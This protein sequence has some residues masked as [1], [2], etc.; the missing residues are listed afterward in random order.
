MTTGLIIDSFS[1][2]GGA[3]TGIRLAMGRDPDIAINHDGAALAMHAANH[4][5]TRHYCESVWAVDPRAATGGQSVALAWF[6]PD[7]KHFSKA[8]GGKP[9]DKGIRGLAWVVLRWAKQARPRVICLENVE[10][11]Q[12]WGPLRK[13]KGQWRPDPDR[14]GETFRMWVSHLQALGYQVEWRTLRA[15]DYGAPTIRKRLFLVARRDGQAIS[16]PQPTHGP[17]LI[18]YR[19][20]AE[21]I[22]WTIPCPSIFDRKKPLADAT[23][24]RIARGLE[25]YVYNNPAPFIVTYYGAKKPG[26]FRGQSLDEPLRTQSTENRFGL[27]APVLVRHFGQSTGQPIDCPAPT[28][29]AGGGGK[30][31]LVSAFLAQ[32]NTGVIG[33]RADAPLST[34]MGTGS[35]QQ[36]VQAFLMKYYGTGGQHQDCRE[37]LHT[38]PTLARH[39]LVTVHGQPHRIVDIGMRMLTPRELFRAQGFPDSYVLDPNH[40]GR[41]LSKA[42]QIRMCGNSVCPDVA[43]ALVRANMATLVREV[44][45]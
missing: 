28:T 24:A 45:A 17:G 37:P 38:I 9:V 16:W 7:C 36:L 6:S 39:A 10:E 19:T 32:H 42:A 4:P 21:I 3:S 5:K 34:I 15:C 31:A 25:K 43:A 33:R 13:V 11:F 12:D 26:E 35:H 8:K 44:A 23:M 29:T 18:P 20:A 30:T 22:D 40:N 2:G 41:P 1:G 27:V 14:K